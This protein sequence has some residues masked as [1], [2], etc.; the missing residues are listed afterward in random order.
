MTRQ[1]LDRQLKRI[2]EIH[3][4]LTQVLLDETLTDM[5]ALVAE[6]GSRLNTV[7][8]AIEADPPSEESQEVLNRLLEDQRDLEQMMQARLES[9]GD[10]LLGAKRNSLVNKKYRFSSAKTNAELVKSMDITG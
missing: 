10:K 7:I 6:L 5:E 4:R 1:D 9:T 3:H 2:T 8:T